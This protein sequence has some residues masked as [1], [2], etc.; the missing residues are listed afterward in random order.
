M[1]VEQLQKSIRE[2]KKENDVCILAHSYQ[3]REI[4]EIAD[5][6]GDSFKLSVEAQKVKN[7]KIVMCGVHFMAETA[8]LLSPEKTV[9]IASDE[10]GC[11]MAEQFTPE[12]VLKFKAEHPSY[13]VV[14]YI[15]TTAALKCVTDVCVT[16]S[17][18]VEIVGKIENNDILFIPDKNLG[19][20]VQKAYPEKN[21]V[22]W[23]GGCP[24]HGKMTAADVKAIKAKFPEAKFLVHPECP[25][26]VCENADYIGSTAGII[27]YARK[28][29]AEQ[30]IIGTEISITAQ[31][32]YEMPAKRFVNLSKHLICTDMKAT[33]LMDVYNAVCG[34][35][36]L[37]INFDA[38]T[39]A[40]ARHC[41][42]EMIRLG[43]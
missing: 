16:S 4:C 26:E 32:S 24:V 11:P 34:K 37:E 33:T 17:S 15:N 31:L 30:F 1:T 22:C 3:T 8:K 6:V 13:S 12:E 36:G 41:I 19:A 40:K 27:D 18:A 28:S 14:S 5:I 9:V 7:S 38:D 43:G 21:I 23:N 42:D 35:G 10:A 2:L 29:D 39:A 20:F 25:P